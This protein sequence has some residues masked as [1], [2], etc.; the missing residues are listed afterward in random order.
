MIERT[1]K[2]FLV[3]YGS[4]LLPA[5]VVRHAARRTAMGAA[6]ARRARPQN[7]FLRSLRLPHPSG[8]QCR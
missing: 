7:R 4:R 1:A 3:S 6:A 8:W 2:R 5:V